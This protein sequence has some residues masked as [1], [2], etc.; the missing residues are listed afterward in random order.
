M[1]KMV[2]RHPLAADRTRLHV[3][4]F[5]TQAGNPKSRRSLLIPLYEPLFDSDKESPLQC[6]CTALQSSANTHDK[7]C[8]IDQ[9][10]SRGAGSN[11]CRLS[12]AGEKREDEIAYSSLG[13]VRNK[14]TA[15][16]K[17]KKKRLTVSR[18]VQ[19]LSPQSHWCSW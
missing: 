19:C 12:S 16:K 10:A 9:I 18:A 14:E 1:G 13:R 15:K 2:V 5:S 17:R 6:T 8:L 4:F 7:R 3:K 11:A